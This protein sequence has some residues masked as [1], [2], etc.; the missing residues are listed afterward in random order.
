M[1]YSYRSKILFR[2]VILGLI[3]FAFIYAIHQKQ[4]YFTSI[5]LA[6]IIIAS[7]I[8]LIYFSENWMREFKKFLMS[9]KHRDFTGFYY[10]EKLQKTIPE[11]KFA[12][13]EISR[14][15]QNVRIEKELHYQ[16]LQ[17][18]TN[19]IKIALICCKD[20]GSVQLANPAAN[21]L[22][23]VHQLRS[24]SQ[25]ENISPDLFK[26]IKS[27]PERSKVIKSV[28]K[29]KL[30]QLVIDKS[31]F[32]LGG[33]HLM[34][35]SFRDINNEL[36]Q[37]ELESWKKLIQVLTHEIMNSATPISSL[38]KATLDILDSY[39]QNSSKDIVLSTED[40]E[41]LYNSIATIENRGRGMQKFVDDY[42]NLMKIP[43]PKFE[44]V[45]V[46]GLLSYTKNLLAKEF[47]ARGI[48]IELSIEPDDLTIFADPDMIE[49]VILNLMLNAM[50]AMED[51]PK[52]KLLIFARPDSSGKILISIKDNGKGIPEENMDKIFV[53][54]FTTR[55]GGSGLGLGISREIL[56]QHQGSIEVESYENEGTRV[57]L[58]F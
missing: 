25:V 37:N 13:K 3:M 49:R 29:G 32:I 31:N 10:D 7:T 21:E 45:N 1:N 41:D 52:P 15:F 40:F 39:K 58:L 26:G 9:I 16:Y 44:Q 19:H 23:G 51:E 12:F 38:S 50:Y 8:E 54:F 6:I 14:E 27:T 24:L 56:R 55:K 22:F 53:P 28:F 47:D 46:S 4:W 11:Y 43:Q 42:K 34:L 35:V 30:R 20:D 5:I 33:E 48:K 57:S 17:T 2:I 18:I 36:E